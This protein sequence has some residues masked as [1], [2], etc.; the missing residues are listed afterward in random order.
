MRRQSKK[1]QERS[2]QA[3]STRDALIANAGS[4]M[5]CGASPRKPVH[6]FSALNQLCCHE[7]AGGPLRQKFLDLP[8]GILVLCYYC[9][10]YEVEDKGKWPQSRQLAVL[11]QKSPENYDLVAFNH[12]VNPNAPNRIEQYEVDKWLESDG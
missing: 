12:A 9:N 3:K 4:C 6:S 1:F 7:I 2:K 11:L 8:F 10:Q 5:I